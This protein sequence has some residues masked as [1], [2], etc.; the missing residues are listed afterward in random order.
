M[1]VSLHEK[2]KLKKGK[3]VIG[4]LFW[5]A[6]LATLCLATIDHYDQRGV[7]FHSFITPFSLKNARP[8]SVALWLKRDAKSM[9][10]SLHSPTVARVHAVS[11][12]SS[13]I[14]TIGQSFVRR[15]P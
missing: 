15:Y 5:I 14:A 2:E 7:E 13:E 11:F 12:Q 4:R 8:P 3:I 6:T 1:H 10:S 9:E